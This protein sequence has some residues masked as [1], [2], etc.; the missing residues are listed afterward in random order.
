MRA[1]VCAMA[2]LL[3]LLAAS[4]GR[5]ADQGPVT[6]SYRVP[7]RGRFDITVPPGWQ[8]SFAQ[9]SPRSMPILTFT[10]AGRRDPL[11]QVSL[12]WDGANRRDFNAPAAIRRMV[13]QAGAAA[14][15]SAVEPTVTIADLAG[16]ALRGHYFSLTD[17]GMQGKQPGADDY[18]YL[19]Q[20]AAA[21]GPLI[22]TF[23]ILSNARQTPETAVALSMIAGARH[24]A[25]D[26]PGGDTVALWLPGRPWLLRLDLPGFFLN[27]NEAAPDGVGRNVAAANE[28][29]GVTV[30]VFLEPV[31]G[32][33]DPAACRDRYWTKYW[34]EAEGKVIQKSDVAESSLVGFTTTE[35]VIHRIPDSLLPKELAHLRG[36]DLNQKHVNAYLGREGACADVHLSKMNFR[37]ED[38]RLFEAVLKGVRV[39]AR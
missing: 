9:Q 7:E 22:V 24:V 30:T 20:G 12:I 27:V 19:T 35:Y 21:T 29:T 31:G 26:V 39:E 23:T 6:R 38:E 17:R 13:D 11:V 3:A 33:T 25:A 14:L 10:P 32:A 18:R 36:K 1:I 5:A 34:K 16:P 2:A 28:A 37:P 4:P 15:R 8:D